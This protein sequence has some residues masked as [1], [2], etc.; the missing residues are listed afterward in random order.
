[1][2]SGLLQ[3]DQKLPNTENY[4]KGIIKCK[5]SAISTQEILKVLIVRNF[6]PCTALSDIGFLFWCYFE[7]FQT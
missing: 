5:V 3:R 6:L 1:M 4:P 2:L 7:I